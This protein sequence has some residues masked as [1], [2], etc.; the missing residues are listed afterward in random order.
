[1]EY[2]IKLSAEAAEPEDHAG[3]VSTLDIPAD[4]A[5][6]DVDYTHSEQDNQRKLY[7]R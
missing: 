2:W 4:H 1:M 5:I 6:G 7:H 3:I